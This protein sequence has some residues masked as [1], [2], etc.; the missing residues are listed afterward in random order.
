MSLFIIGPVVA[1]TLRLWRDKRR[2]R[3]VDPFVIKVRRFHPCQSFSLACWRQ[4]GSCCFF[5]FHLASSLSSFCSTLV[6]NRSPI[7]GDTWRDRYRDDA[8]LIHRNRLSKALC[9]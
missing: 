8:T 7:D 1:R 9:Y 5:L 3:A 4:F 2:G 6:F